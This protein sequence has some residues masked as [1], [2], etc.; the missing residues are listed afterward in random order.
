MKDKTLQLMCNISAFLEISLYS[1][2][3]CQTAIVFSYSGY[4]PRNGWVTQRLNKESIK[5]N[6]NFKTLFSSSWGIQS[7][8]L[9]L[10]KYQNI[11]ILLFSTWCVWLI[12]PSSQRVTTL[13]YMFFFINGVKL[14]SD[15]FYS[16]FP[17][18]LQRCVWKVSPML[19]IISTTDNGFLF[20]L[21]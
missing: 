12:H 1:G 13:V 7:G 15:R 8:I 10:T 14:L 16:L 6:N 3:L 21:S 17:R 2:Q 4:T 19:K 9:I 18:I 5:F 20:L 11:Y